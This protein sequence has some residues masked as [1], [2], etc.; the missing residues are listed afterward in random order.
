MPF[1]IVVSLL[2][3]G[4]IAFLATLVLGMALS[5]IGYKAWG[6]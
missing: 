5:S 3:L 6:A 4:A 2:V 1:I